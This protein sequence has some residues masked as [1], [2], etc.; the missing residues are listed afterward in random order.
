MSDPIG[1]RSHAQARKDKSRARIDN[2]GARV[3]SEEDEL[4]REAYGP[5]GAAMRKTARTVN[6]ALNVKQTEQDSTMLQKGVARVKRIFGR[7]KE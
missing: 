7:D 2:M 4:M 6:T 3:L 1:A 5:K